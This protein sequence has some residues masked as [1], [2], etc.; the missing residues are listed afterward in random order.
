MNVLRF[1]EQT[2]GNKL[3]KREKAKLGNVLDTKG[4]LSLLY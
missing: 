4:S 2:T 1:V 3:T